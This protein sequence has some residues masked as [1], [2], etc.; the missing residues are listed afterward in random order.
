MQ[1]TQGGVRPLGFF[2]CKVEAAVCYAKWAKAF[3]SGVGGAGLVAPTA[4]KK[5]PP[6]GAHKSKGAAV[7]KFFAA[8]KQRPAAAGG[9]RTSP[10]EMVKVRTE[11]QPKP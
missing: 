11:P 2:A 5:K 6:S 4:I 7:T 10:A 1:T 9:A 3:H 8:R